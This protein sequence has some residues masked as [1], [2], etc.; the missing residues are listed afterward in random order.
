MKAKE[1]F[2]KL[3]F[4][5][6]SKSNRNVIY[7]KEREGLDL[8]VQFCKTGENVQCHFG[9]GVVSGRCAMPAYIAK[10]VAKQVE[11][12]GWHSDAKTG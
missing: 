9:E 1:M 10:A 11:E 8:F 3:G 2:E 7:R 4:E 6:W 12:L 5:K